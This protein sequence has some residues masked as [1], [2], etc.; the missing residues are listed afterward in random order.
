[1]HAFLSLEADGR[2]WY[3][4]QYSKI[5]RWFDGNQWQNLAFEEEL[6]ALEADGNGGYW[7]LY[8]PSTQPYT[9]QLQ[10]Y[11]GNTFSVI[12]LPNTISN[13]FQQMVL[14]ANGDLWIKENTGDGPWRFDGNSWTQH[15]LGCY[16]QRLASDDNGNIFLDCSNGDI[17]QWV[18][19]SWVNIHTGTGGTFLDHALL[20]IP[21][22]TNSFWQT[23]YH[24]VHRI[25]PAGTISYNSSNAPLQS[26]YTE[27]AAIDSNG[28]FWTLSLFPQE[29]IRF[30][31]QGFQTYPADSL[32]IRLDTASH[33]AFDVDGH[34]WVSN[35]SSVYQFG[36]QTAPM[37]T[38]WPGDANDDLIANYLDFLDLGIAFGS[39]GPI[40]ANA[41]TNWQAEPVFSWSNTLP[42]GA[43]YAHTDTDG[44]GT[45]DFDDTLAIV[46]NYGLTHNKSSG[47][48]QTGSTPL[49]IL[50]D[51]STY[52]PGDT[53]YAPIVLG[54]DTLIA[55]SVYG[56]GFTISYD[57]L[58][59]DSGSVQI[60]FG[61]SWL[62]IK[63]QDMI[64][65]ARDDYNNGQI[66]I[67][68]SRN[69][70]T[71]RSGFGEIAH[72]RVVMID[73]I[74]GKDILRDTMRFEISG[75]R[76][77]RK[78]D[79]PIPYDTEIATIEVTQEVTNLSNDLSSQW[80]VYPNPAQNE[81]IIEARRSAKRQTNIR[82]YNLQGK[83]LI[84]QRL[85]GDQ[86]RLDLTALPNALY[87]LQITD[88]QDVYQQKIQKY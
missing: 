30:D 55:D 34:L 50:P 12:S 75:V 84:Q 83:L 16:E 5:N 61:N 41:T 10:Y 31:D 42:N 32:G 2:I 20:P 82:L 46:L 24:E 52:Q 85:I 43:N 35:V 79:T 65:F 7:L 53:V 57:P 13:Y 18:G 8:E 21:G 73:D 76:L 27:R 56:L 33:L 37:D 58:L 62:G 6:L 23:S 63:N 14:A 38:V 25:S 77:I 66:D 17:Y 4:G 22:Q 47:T 81:L 15:P 51:F 70:Q 54:L 88:E 60:D 67:A 19:N 87:L 40:R 26:A 69:D 80:L 78:D 74:S 64:S 28:H 3:R 59:V 86:A 72:M 45:A 44:S 49:L 71:E 48:A 39:S 9:S 36:S 1:N 68:L 11:D 29:L